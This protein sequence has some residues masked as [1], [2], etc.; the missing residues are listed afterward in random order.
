MNKVEIPTGTLPLKTGIADVLIGYRTVDGRNFI[1]NGLQ[2]D[3]LCF[4]PEDPLPTG[5]LTAKYDSPTFKERYKIPEGMWCHHASCNDQIG[6]G[7][8]LYTDG[9]FVEDP[10]IQF[11]N[12]SDEWADIDVRRLETC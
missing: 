3:G 8:I 11:A 9:T 10:A 6:E 1:L 7:Y 4:F 12:E 2:L 5:L